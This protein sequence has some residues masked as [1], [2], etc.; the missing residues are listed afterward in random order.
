MQVVPDL[1]R[2]TREGNLESVNLILLR[3]RIIHSD[4]ILSMETAV[5]TNR[6]DILKV[7]LSA[8]RLTSDDLIS[9]LT[10]IAI[11]SRSPTVLK[12]LLT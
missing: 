9:K 2:H 4:L 11:L 6:L 10:K 1:V 8:V 3:K 7:L 5:H 12:Y